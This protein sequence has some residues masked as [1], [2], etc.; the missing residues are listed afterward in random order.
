MFYIFIFLAIIAQPYIIK[1]QITDDRRQAVEVRQDE[2]FLVNQ[3][4][5]HC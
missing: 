1:P 4:P 3:I 2:A 5:K